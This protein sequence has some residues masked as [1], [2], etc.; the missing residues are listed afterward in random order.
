MPG[1]TLVLASSSP[2]RLELCRMHGLAPVVEPADIDETPQPEESPA[3]L[4]GRLAA[5]KATVVRDRIDADLV[6]AADT[7]VVI[8]GEALG[9]PHDAETSAAMLRRLSGRRHEVLT[10]V[11]LAGPDRVETDVVSTAV[12]FRALDDD[13][14][15]AYVGTGEGLDK[16]GAYGIQ[17]RGGLL[18]ERIDGP[19]DN[20][21]GLPIVTVDRLL[22][23]FGSSVVDLAGVPS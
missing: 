11:A 10:G 21:V 12:E 15:T 2:R 23:R 14:L 3:D 5:E 4:V 16:A 1:V 20:V 13:L 19:Y 9:K 7:V 18:V 8:D 6:L 22:A 17:G